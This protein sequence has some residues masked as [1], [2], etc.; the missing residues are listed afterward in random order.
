[1]KESSVIVK[2]IVVQHF[3]DNKEEIKKFVDLMSEIKVEMVEFMIDNKWSMFTN[4]DEKPLPAHYGEL[5]LYFK[6]ECEKKGIK[7][8]MW[9]KMEYILSKYALNTQ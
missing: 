8:K 3:N 7:V 6:E 5:Y 1:M 4:L 9:E 2:Y